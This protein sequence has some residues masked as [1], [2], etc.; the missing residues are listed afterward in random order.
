MNRRVFIGSSF[1]GLAAAQVRAFAANDHV[2]VAM[3]GV[4]GRGRSLLGGLLGT[5]GVKVTHLCDVDTASI[6]RAQAVVKKANAAIPAV[7]GHMR[8]LL[9]NRSLTQ[10]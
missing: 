7:V 2:N 3:I 1:A 9:Q 4:G 8:A 5:S 6:E 10:M